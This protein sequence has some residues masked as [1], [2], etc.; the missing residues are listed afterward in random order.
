MYQVR[1]KKYESRYWRVV[2][3]HATRKEALRA[4]IRLD[5]ANRRDP[6]R[7][8]DSIDVKYPDGT[9]FIVA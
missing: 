4:A 6:D 3:E 5:F 1:T 8:Y 7:V 9:R 2:S